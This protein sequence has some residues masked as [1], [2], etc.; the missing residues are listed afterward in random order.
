MYRVRFASVAILS[1]GYDAQRAMLE[2]EFSG[3]GQI[4]R[5]Y[6]VP[7]DLWYRFRGESSPDCFFNQC[8]KGY[9]VE[10]RMTG[11]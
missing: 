2:V 4:F 6:E 1:A 10:K 3:D 8:I 9:F 11:G 5:Y 7:E